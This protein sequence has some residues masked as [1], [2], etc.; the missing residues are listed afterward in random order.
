[1]KIEQ[2]KPIRVHTILFTE[3]CPLDCRYCDLKH[4]LT[5]G[6]ADQL[7]IEEI[8]RRIEYYNEHDNPDEVNSRLTFTGGEPFLFW[9]RIKEIMLKYGNRFEYEF[10]TSGY[11]LTEDIIKFLAQYKSVNFFL[12]VDGDEN[13]TNY[14]R[15]V[16][17][18]PYRTGYM[19]RFKEVIPTLLYYFPRVSAK[20]ILNPRYVDLLHD[21]YLRLAKIGFRFINI[22]LDFESRPDRAKTGRSITWSDKYTKILYEQVDLIVKDI[23][24]G[25]KN[26]IKYPSVQNLDKVIAFLLAKNTSFDPKKTPCQV[27]SG[28]TLSTMY[29]NTVTEYCMSSVYPNQQ[30]ALEKFQELYN[31]HTCYFAKDKPCPAFEYC[32]QTGCPQKA[33]LDSEK[34]E[35]YV[36]ELEC[37]IYKVFYQA[38]L[39]LLYVCNQMCGDSKL[40]IDYLNNF[41]YEGK[42]G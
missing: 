38:A 5:Y 31:K 28:R 17:A 18:N 36:D 25:F 39:K 24:L 2:A 13:L 27:F 14:L 10:N 16:L 8:Y 4:D 21:Q 19:K 11:L 12:S 40:Y 33:I 15:P 6:T 41:D 20:L 23:T 1:M 32:I 30:D 7:N 26:G 35:F 9:D 22:N 37:V 34:N 3:A 42:E 29:N